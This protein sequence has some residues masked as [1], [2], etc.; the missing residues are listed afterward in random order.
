MIHAPRLSIVALAAVLLVAPGA[1]KAQG[2]LDQSQT[3]GSGGMGIVSGPQNVAQTFTAGRSGNLVRVDLLLQ[4]TP[5]TLPEGPLVV[6]I[7]SVTNGV[8]NGDSFAGSA[9]VPGQVPISPDWRTFVLNRPVPSNAGTQ[10]AIVAISP[11]TSPARGYRW[12]RSAGDLY[13]GGG[14]FFRTQVPVGQ[15]WLPFGGDDMTFRTYVEPVAVGGPPDPAQ[16][17]AELKALL[18]RLGL[19]PRLTERLQSMLDR[20]LAALPPGSSG[21]ASRSLRAFVHRVAAQRGKRLTVAQ[22]RRLSAA[23]RDL[24]ASLALKRLER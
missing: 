9:L 18:D 1:A 3:D 21:R 23:T 13:P 15:P 8:P 16:T 7:E 14:A 24:R 2:A 22:A 4:L 12:F 11:G 17:I 20:V 5:G 19:P 10:Y 6:L